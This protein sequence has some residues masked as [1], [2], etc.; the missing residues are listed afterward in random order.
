[1][2]PITFT[3]NA[4]VRTDTMPTW[5]QKW[6]EVNPVSHLSDAVRGLLSGGPVAS[7]AVTSLLWAAA[8][9]VVFAPLA[10]RAF[11]TRT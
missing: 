10:V 1:M 9:A 11:R 8:I 6:V 3:S 5:L 2:M 7:H 4:F